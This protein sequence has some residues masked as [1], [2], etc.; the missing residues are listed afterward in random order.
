[1]DVI[2][3]IYKVTG[4]PDVLLPALSDADGRL[5][6]SD[7]I[8]TTSVSFTRPADTTQYTV[9]DLV[10]N[11]IAAGSVV[12]P[13]FNVARTAS[14]AVSVRR[15]SLRKSSTST[16][17]AAFRVH[18]YTNSPTG[19]VNG[20]NGAWQTNVAN[21]MGSADIVMDRAFTDAAW[22][23]NDLTFQELFA[24]TPV[25]A[26]IYALV[27]ARG[28]YIPVSGETFTVSVEVLQD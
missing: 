14:G 1:M 13:L 7:G 3:G 22:G 6:V 23:T 28:N 17:N 2:Q 11:S 21:Y 25:N 8:L 27:E 24:K 20:D 19:I 4:Q 26:R 16:L 10:A 5:V 9:G 15:V 18:L 12:V